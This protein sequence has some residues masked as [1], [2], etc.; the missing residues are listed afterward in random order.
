[1]AFSSNSSLYAWYVPGESW[2]SAFT[3]SDGTE[4]SAGYY[5]GISI[6]D[7]LVYYEDFCEDGRNDY[8][9]RLVIST[10]K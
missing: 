8:E 4:M 7:A 6:T 10:P 2:F 9:V 5:R 3:C 1:V